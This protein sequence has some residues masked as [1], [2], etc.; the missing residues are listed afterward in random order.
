MSKHADAFGDRMKSYEFVET[1]RK[2]MKYLPICARIDGKGFS[3]LTKNLER[4]YSIEFHKLMVDTCAY[5]AKKSNANIGYTQSDEMSFVYYDNTTDGQL[6]FDGKIMKLTSV[7]CSLATAYFNKN[8]HRVPKL[9]DQLAEFDCRVWTV[10][11]TVEAINT[12]VWRESD[13]T[14]N[15]V[16]MAA[17]H[18]EKNLFG[19]NQPQMQDLLHRHGVNWNDY[20]DFF[21][22][23]TYIVRVATCMTEEFIE[24]KLAGKPQDVIDRA[25]LEFIKRAT[26]YGPKMRNDYVPTTLRQIKT[27]EDRERLLQPII[28]L[29]VYL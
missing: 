16:S 14:K 28:N 22:R 21:K 24:S 6:Y 20:P 18:Y 19:L 5:V 25:K 1:G 11:N 17:R 9:G 15:S 26:L 3:K 13:A 23:G 12:L 27:I 2:A 29:N 4:P 10:P 8:M 7:L